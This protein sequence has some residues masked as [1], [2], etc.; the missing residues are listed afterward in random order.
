MDYRGFICEIKH[1]GMLG[2][3]TLKRPKSLQISSFLTQ[4]QLSL[5]S[6]LSSFRMDR[7]FDYGSKLETSE[8][9]KIVDFYKLKLETAIE[10][11][12]AKRNKDRLE[13]GH[14]TYSY[15]Q[16]SWLTNGIQA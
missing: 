12:L 2:E 10:P 4:E 9:K 5:V 1:L 13:E 8:G 3:H 15:M 7:L 14:L 11:V 16:P 6:E